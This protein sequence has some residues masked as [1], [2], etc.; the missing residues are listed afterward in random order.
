MKK[1]K[2]SFF[3]N[4]AAATLLSAFCVYLVYF[5]N[6]NAF[7]D[8]L[9]MHT[10]V[11]FYTQIF[12]L[13]LPPLIQTLLLKNEISREQVVHLILLVFVFSIL[14]IIVFLSF[15]PLSKLFWYIP[16]LSLYYNL[17]AME[18][19]SN[20]KRQY[21]NL[22][23]F[24]GLNLLLGSILAHYSI[25][26]VYLPISVYALFYL[27]K[28]YNY[29]GNRGI[30]NIR[31]VF[32]N[33]IE[34]LAFYTSNIGFKNIPFYLTFILRNDQFLIFKLVYSVGTFLWNIVYSLI[35][36]RL[37]SLQSSSNIRDLRVLFDRFYLTKSLLILG[38]ILYLSNLL[39]FNSGN[40]YLFSI[41]V[42]LTAVVVNLSNSFSYSMRR[43]SKRVLTDILV[44]ALLIL[45]S[46]PGFFTL[47]LASH[48]TVLVFLG[49]MF[50]I[51]TD[52]S[53][54]KIG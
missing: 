3:L 47:K 2:G 30:L 28:S 27:F 22:L 8:F 29:N 50:I 33:G 4:R 38:L 46:F 36:Q 5:T 7:D 53:D 14:L 12:T 26:F 19:G 42:T 11:F 24:F 41:L 1:V 16:F 31:L 6:R 10:Q 17:L 40:I 15:L 18:T 35:F 23:W 9:V 25:Y 54:E 13:G 43:S 51:N 20:I 21:F 32:G 34:I 45:L 39:F 52:L 44:G 48:L 37:L 49:F